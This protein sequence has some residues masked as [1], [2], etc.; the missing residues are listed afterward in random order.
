MG[1]VQETIASRECQNIEVRFARDFS[2]WQKADRGGRK[3]KVGASKGPADEES[4]IAFK[5][6][7]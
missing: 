1:E 3:S 4:G 2:R 5:S 6:S 7:E